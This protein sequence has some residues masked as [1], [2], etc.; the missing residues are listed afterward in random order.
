MIAPLSDV[1]LA[2]LEAWCGCEQCPAQVG[3][4]I[5]AVCRELRELRRVRDLVIAAAASRGT[6]QFDRR[7]GAAVDAARGQP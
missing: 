1:E 2:Q 7:W 6:P 3:R 4:E 5:L